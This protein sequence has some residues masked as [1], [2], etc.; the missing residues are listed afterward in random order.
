[1]NRTVKHRRAAGV[2]TL[3]GG[4]VDRPAPWQLS[5]ISAHAELLSAARY[6]AVRRAALL[7]VEL[8]RLNEELETVRAELRRGRQELGNLSDRSAARIA[9]LSGEVSR[10]KRRNERYLGALVTLVEAVGRESDAGHLLGSA[11]AAADLAHAT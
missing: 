5:E 8:V 1:M 11:I 2:M 10:L 7:E 3:I 4:D 9:A 6:A